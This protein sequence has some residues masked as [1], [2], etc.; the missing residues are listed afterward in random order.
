V[1]RAIRKFF[2][3]N[4]EERGAKMTFFGQSPNISSD[5]LTKHYYD[6]K[7]LEQLHHQQVSEYLPK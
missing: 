2:G 7:E 5:G 3:F 1:F 4:K 6:G